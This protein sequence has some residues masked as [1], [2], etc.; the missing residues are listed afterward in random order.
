MKLALGTVQFGL[1]YGVANA[2]GRVDAEIAKAILRRA[3]EYGMDTLDTA[4]T[5]GASESV[6]GSLN[7]QAWKVVTK[8]PLVPDKCSDLGSW[9]NEQVHGSLDRLG[10]TRVHGLLLHRPRQLLENRGPS[11]YAALQD[12]KE[13]GLVSKIGISVYGPAELDSIFGKYTFDLVQAPLNILDRSLV[14]SGWVRQLKDA[15]VEIH[16]RSAFLQGLLLMNS[17]MRPSKFNRWSDIW[18]EWDR[19]LS[20]TG[21]SPLQACLNYTN[22]LDGIDRVVV[23]VDT[24]AQLEEIIEAAEGELNSLPEFKP[25]LDDRLINP[26]SWKQL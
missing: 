24:L 16:T 17:A 3:Q 18:A 13:Q 26:A 7:V 5:Y 4:I 23:G 20:A 22:T 10:V 8:L 25:L 1:N 15:G 12:I 19:W 14:D 21:L 11:L 2:T 6:L 9:V